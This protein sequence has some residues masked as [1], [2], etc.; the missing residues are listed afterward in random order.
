MK[1]TIKKHIAKFWVLLLVLAVFISCQDR[2][3]KNNVVVGSAELE[4]QNDLKEILK[5]N[6]LTVLA[7]NSATSYFIYKGQKMGLEYEIL[8][9][10]ARDLGVKLEIQV[11]KN[12][13]E[14]IDKLN[15]GEGDLISCN[16]TITN[17]RRRK[18]DFSEPFMRTSQVLIQ[19]KPDDWKNK[20]KSQWKKELITEPDQL[21]RKTIHVW[22]NSSYY[23]RLINLQSELGD[24][25][26]LKGLDGNVIPEDV[27]E[28]V[29]KGFIDYTVTDK[30]VALINQRFY[31]NIDATLELSVK[32]K[33]AFGIRKSSPL[34]RKRL[35]AWLKDFMK[36][37]T[38][39]YIKHKYLNMSSFSG[40]AKQEYSSINGG[41]ISPYDREI[42]IAAEKYGWDWRLLASLI[43]QESKFKTGSES[44]AGA[45]GLMQFMPGTGPTY[46]V[47][48]NSTP[49]VQIEGGMKKIHKNFQQWESIPDSIQRVKFTLGTY[50]AGIGH[51]LDAQRLAKKYGKDPTIWDDNVEVYIK[52]LSKPEFYQD[53][54][55]YY[56]YLRGTETFNYVRSI[57]IRYKEY[58]TAFPA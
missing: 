58:K 56:G 40:K 52:R 38:Y 37:S 15:R 7:E 31:P 30:N 21:S 8:K 16:Y 22:K 3:E 45:Y 46:G 24:T 54:V 36:T 53:E 6:K 48:P 44:W 23:E 11:V 29:S 57:F 1:E 35:N 19:R 42:K 34:L 50:N 39:H 12:L 41:V 28:M 51:I 55:C 14:I 47:Y 18:I 10:F 5:A 20:R 26:F 49:S 25:I 13:D 2:S 4:A 43:F 9:E 27:I 33:I 17:E 32:Q